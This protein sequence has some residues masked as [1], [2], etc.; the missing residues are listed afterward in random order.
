MYHFP[1]LLRDLD[2]SGRC[3][4]RTQD[5]QQSSMTCLHSSNLSATACT[6]LYTVDGWLYFLFNLKGTVSRDKSCI[7]INRVR[8]NRINQSI[9][10]SFLNDFLKILQMLYGCLPKCKTSFCK[11]AQSKIFFASCLHCLHSYTRPFR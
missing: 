10:F 7:S 9:L 1:I 6:V 2:H 8:G 4:I 3:P 11:K 5:H